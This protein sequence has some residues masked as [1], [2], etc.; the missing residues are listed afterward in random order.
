[1][2]TQVTSPNAMTERRLRLNLLHK[3]INAEFDKAYNELSYENVALCFPYV[4]REHPEVMK[5]AYEQVKQAIRPTFEQGLDKVIKDYNLQTKLDQLDEIVAEAKQR[6]QTPQETGDATPWMALP[7]GSERVHRMLREKTVV[8]KQRELQDL[9]AS[10]HQL[11]ETNTAIKRELDK[12]QTELKAQLVALFRST[13]KM[14]NLLKTMQALPTENL[15]E[16]AENI[17]P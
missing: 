6:S 8:A 4:A 9:T 10:Y 17:T 15:A 13:Q 3:V 12:R 5:A 2:E 7:K 11:S 16:F 1:M 14:E